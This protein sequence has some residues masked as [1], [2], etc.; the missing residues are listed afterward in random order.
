LLSSK[1]VSICSATRGTWVCIGN[2]LLGTSQLIQF[3][4]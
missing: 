3:G 1:S 2:M 4:I